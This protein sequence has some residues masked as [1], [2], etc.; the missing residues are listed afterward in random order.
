[1]TLKDVKQESDRES[2]NKYTDE[3][4]LNEKHLTLIY[5]TVSEVIFLLAVEP[6]D[7]FRFMSVNR[8]FLDVTGLSREQVVGKKIEQ[9]L[10]ETA[11]ALVISK[12]KE[13]ITENKTVFWEE[14][15]TY[16]TGELVGAVTVTPV[17]TAGGVCTHLV[18]SVHDITEI[19]RV[20]EKLKKNTELL[21]SIMDSATKEIIVATD[22]EGI[23]L[24]WNDG[25][26][27][28]LGYESKEVV[29][30]ESIRIF[31]T[32]EY[33]KSGRMDSNIKN[34]IA[35][36]EPLEE[37]IIYVDK[38]GRSFPAYQ[39]V[40]PRFGAEG[41]FLGTLGLTRDIT[42]RK[43][44]EEKLNASEDKYSTLVEKGND[45]II[46][47]QDFVVK[48][49]N[50]RMIEF[51][52]FTKD[53]V[54]GKP[55]YNFVSSEYKELVAERVKKRLNGEAIPNK[56]EIDIFSEDGSSI[57]VEI[58]ASLIEYEG[59]PADMAIIRD[60]SERRQA[61][62]KILKLNEELEHRVTERTAELERRNEELEQMNKVFIGREVRMA[63]L[64]EQI[65]ELEKDIESGKKAGDKTT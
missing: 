54:I 9:V 56:Y 10:P 13:A 30:K 21:Q 64:K 11:H 22:P 3:M 52:G 6:D 36:R 42:E 45:G 47:I 24:S 58:N 27:R 57:P 51:T 48:F 39:I 29:G 28:L 61:E 32:E 63:E 40:T 35:T 19:R 15:S 65:A 59:R 4:E 38:D 5:D 31:H 1:M 41:E 44:A 53:E 16:P 2:L 18:G 20:E 25:A 60:I 37:E 49:V 46:I 26:R 8:A 7:R 34:M 12:Y 62:D 33:L 50:S 14:I 23:I 17:R 55:F 43:Q